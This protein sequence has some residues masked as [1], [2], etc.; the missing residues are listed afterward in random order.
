MANFLEKEGILGV[1]GIR[2]R[3]ERKVGIV[4]R[5]N[6]EGS[7]WQLSNLDY[8]GRYIKW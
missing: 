8:S 6:H 5:K 2:D 7:L 3:G 1:L 4:T